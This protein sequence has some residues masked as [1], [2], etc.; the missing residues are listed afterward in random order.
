MKKIIVVGVILLF[1][2]SGVPCL[3][4]TQF[5]FFKIPS[6]I[7]SSQAENYTVYIGAGVNREHGEKFGLGWHMAVENTGDVNI[8]GFEYNKEITLFGKVVDNGSGHF[9]LTPG[10]GSKS[11]S[12]S[13]D[14][15][16]ITFIYLSVVIENI[17]YSKS[18]YGIGPFV[19][20]VS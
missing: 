11:A 1:L 9:F 8:S 13:I 17:T 10:S 6:S 4:K 12:W 20:L 19:F 3:A 18:G 5:S 2:G 14:F 16:P 7:S 15:H